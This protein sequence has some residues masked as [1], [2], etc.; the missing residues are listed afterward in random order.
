MNKKSAWPWVTD[1]MSKHHVSQKAHTVLRKLHLKRNAV[2]RFAL[3]GILPDNTFI[4][5]A[6][7]RE[8]VEAVCQ[9]CLRVATANLDRRK[10]AL[11][12]GSPKIFA[13]SES[14]KKD[15]SP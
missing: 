3:C 12:H 5:A 14:T 13:P 9:T 7:P 4:M 6:M 15:V 2:D 11:P 8:S 1:G 10:L